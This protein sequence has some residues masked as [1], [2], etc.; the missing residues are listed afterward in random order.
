MKY[1]LVG[2]RKMDGVYIALIWG[3]EKETWGLPLAKDSAIVIL[4][5]TMLR[6]NLDILDCTLLLFGG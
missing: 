6:I 1:I 5:C 4:V 3:I 2:S